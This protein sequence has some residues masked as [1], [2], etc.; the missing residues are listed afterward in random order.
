MKQPYISDEL[1][2]FLTEAFPPDPPS[3]HEDLKT[4]YYRA[5]QAAMLQWLENVK[6]KQENP[7]V[8]PDDAQA[9]G[10]DP[11]KAAAHARRTRR[12]A[13][14]L[15]GRKEA[16]ARAAEGAERDGGGGQGTS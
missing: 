16:A 12:S 14:R 4:L 3:L 15:A 9:T 11:R 5:G 13:L 6:H 1:L 7:N 10:T 8:F 2:D